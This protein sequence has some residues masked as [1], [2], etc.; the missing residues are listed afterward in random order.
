MCLSR[1]FSDGAAWPTA[2][3]NIQNSYPS[4]W[5]VLRPRCVDW[6]RLLIEKVFYCDRLRNICSRRLEES[7]PFISL[8]RRILDGCVVAKRHEKIDN[9][10][11]FG[12]RG[13]VRNVE[14]DYFRSA[15][16]WAGSLLGVRE[17]ANLDIFLCLG[18]F[19]P[20][21]KGQKLD[22]LLWYWVSDPTWGVRKFWCAHWIT[23][24]S[25]T[26][27]TWHAEL[28][29]DHPFFW[30]ANA[31]KTRKYR[32]QLALAGA[33]FTQGAGCGKCS[34]PGRFKFLMI[35]YIWRFIF[36]CK[37]WS[38]RKKHRKYHR[39]NNPPDASWV[40]FF[41]LKKNL[42]YGK[43]LEM[44]IVQDSHALAKIIARK[45]CIS[46]SIYIYIYTLV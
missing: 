44:K 1:Q 39:K 37:N 28:V 3:L 15:T 32:Q 2:I 17:T 38:A 35:S 25:T 24:G 36:L 14:L 33:G 9:C 11:Y 34:T 16:S 46:I 5:F 42:L 8:L 13:K 18:I 40:P 20:R 4:W 45:R 23:P 31:H 22:I 26:W 10:D 43:F 30:M 12:W 21:L 7:S 29:A 41:A 19:L 27:T 6:K